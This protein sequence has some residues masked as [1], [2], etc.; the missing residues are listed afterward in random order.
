MQKQAIT[1]LD[2]DKATVIIVKEFNSPKSTKVI[3]QDLGTRKSYLISKPAGWLN[4]PV[5]QVLQT[6]RE[7]YTSTNGGNYAKLTVDKLL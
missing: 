3:I 2:F 5:G 1:R 7:F 6:H 4:L